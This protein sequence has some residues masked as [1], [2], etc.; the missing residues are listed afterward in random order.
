MGKQP[1][2]ATEQLDASFASDNVAGVSPEILQALTAANTESAL[3]Y[4][5][6]LQTSALTDWAKSEF[7]AQAEIYPVFNGTGANV[8]GLQ[9]LLDRWGAA[10]CSVQAHVNNDEGAAPERVGAL[11][12]LPRPTVDGKLRPADITAELSALGFVHAAQPQ[13]VTLTQST[14]LGT[15]YS[16]DELA[17]LAETAHSHGLG[18]HIDGARI[19]NAAAALGT[20]LAGITSEIGAD[21][22]SLGATKNGALAAEAVVVINPDRVRGTEFIRKFSMQLASKQRFLSAQLVELFGTELWRR[23]AEHANAQAAKLGQALAALEGVSITGSTVVN[24]VFPEMPQEMAA[25]IQSAYLA[26]VWDTA[27][28]GNP[29]LRLMCNWQTTDAQLDALV[30]VAAG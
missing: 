9:G 1:V 30:A 14:E 19:S 3:P 11:K 27:P 2:E 6:D 15:L 13:A 8:V 29:V 4:G 26:H 10:I 24:A 17:E 23:N 12:L 20:S 28:S 22:L 25:R 18:V 7:G 21:V 5:G 16:R